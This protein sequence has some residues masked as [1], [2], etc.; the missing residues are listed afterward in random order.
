MNFLTRK[1]ACFL[2]KIPP[3]F[4]LSPPGKIHFLP[5]ATWKKPEKNPELISSSRYD[6]RDFE[7]FYFVVVR[8]STVINNA[9]TDTYT[10]TMAETIS[11]H[12]EK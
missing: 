1:I 7:Y 8:I 5:F 9:M 4:R 3:D 2:D 10:E 12:R 11:P 6:N